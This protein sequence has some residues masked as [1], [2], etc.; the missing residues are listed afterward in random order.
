[1]E[2]LSADFLSSLPK[3]KW[4][5]DDII[6]QFDGFWFRLPYLQGTLKLLKDFKPLPTDV[7]LASFPK[8]GTTWL[9]SLLFA[10]TQR[11][12]KALLNSTNPH[13][14]VPTL[15]LQVYSANPTQADML[16]SCDANPRIFST[17]V[18]YQI[19]SK[20]A[21]HSSECRI[22]YVTRNPKDTLISL[23]HFVGKSQMSQIKPWPIEEAVDRFCDGV[24]PYGPYYDHVSQFRKESLERPQR[25]YFVSYE[26]LKIDT[27]NQVKSLAEFLG[28]PFEK[29]EEA[30]EIV[31]MC[32]IQ[33]LKQ[34]EINKSSDLP[35]WFELPYNSFFRQGEVG[36]YKN[37]LSSGMIQRIDDM[38]KDKF[39]GAGL[40]FGV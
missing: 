39:H 19:L 21:I 2:Q 3:H 5:R 1:M 16:T 23:W 34:H 4:C 18:P 24:V 8:T 27:K 20:S 37:H 28:C 36:D 25:V 7:I 12:S 40:M 14:L 11:S 35:D 26:E 6:Y 38:T 31:K 9:K 22:V 29:E 13:D 15:E 10:I 33:T 32:D 17:H 30:E